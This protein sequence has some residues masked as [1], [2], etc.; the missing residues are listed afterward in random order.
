MNKQLYKLT[1]FVVLLS[2]LLAACQ[3]AAAPT[4]VPQPTTAPTQEVAAPT[5]EPAKPIEPPAAPPPTEPPAKAE[6]V[7]LE[8]W[9]GA[10]VSEAGPPPDDWVVYQIAKDKLGINLKVVLLPTAQTD[11]DAKINAAA[12]ANAL[13]DLFQ[14]NREPWYRLVQ[15]NLVAPVDDLLPM[16]P[17][18]TKILY[19]N[20]TSNKLVT[21]DGKMYGLPQPG[22]LP[23]TDALVIRKDWLD[24]LGLEVP[25]TLD[26]MMAVAMAFTEKDPDGNGKKDT[27]GFCGYIESEGLGALP[28]LG[29]RFE[30]VLGAYGLNGAWDLSG[31]DNFQLNVRNPNFM[32]AVEYVKSLNDAGVVDPDWPTLKKDEFRA[33]WKQGK[34]GIMNE[35]F[36]ALST[37]ANYA[38]FDKN[39]P[40][41][42]W[43]VIAPPTGPE[44]KSSEGVD[45]TNVRIFAMSQKAKDAGKADAIARLLEW[46]ESD[47]GYYLIGF[48]QEGVNYK[49][50]ANGF[51]TT[52]D[53][54]PEKAYTNKSQQP[55]TQLRNMVFN[56]SPVELK[57]RYV[58]YKTANGRTMDPLQYLEQYRAQPWTEGTGWSIINPP[59]GGADFTR[60]YSENLVKFALGQQPLN[61]QTWKEF[62]DGLDGLGAKDYE[63]QAKET[64]QNSGFLK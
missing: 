43:I 61:E 6:P 28:G 52:K 9:V 38:D 62:I 11:A 8:V 41:G 64:L 56:N 22:A 33:R 32:K 7:D 44:G 13:P 25:K 31:A 3:P 4:Q 55:L 24:K 35:N 19:T 42:E 50:D 46:M 63:A 60:F 47:E 51:V 36:A 37:K 49:K 26:D 29:K 39:F 40:E 17:N 53:I 14:V 5:A 27:Y 18:R 16:M 48:G 54:D 10:S 2:L 45:L 59:P 23:R 57:S 20:D 34:C 15:N 21:L 12:A 58:A 1:L 30:W